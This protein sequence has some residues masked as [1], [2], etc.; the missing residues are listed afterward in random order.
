[1]GGGGM[2]HFGNFSGGVRP[3]SGKPYSILDQNME[4]S[5]PY[6]RP[7]PK[8]HTQFRPDPYPISFA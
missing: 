5:L 1:M 6:F 7:D 8:F 2:V 4:L 3:A